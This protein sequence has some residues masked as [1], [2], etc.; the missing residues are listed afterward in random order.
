MAVI[1]EEVP[2]KIHEKPT[3]IISS[4]KTKVKYR[5]A[6]L[7]GGFIFYGISTIDGGKLPVELQGSYT[8]MARA[9]EAFQKYERVM[10][11]TPAVK[12]DRKYEENH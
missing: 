4:T 10:E 5:I 2:P 6:P 8:S 9:L 11:E 1:V 7:P 3:Q 12:R